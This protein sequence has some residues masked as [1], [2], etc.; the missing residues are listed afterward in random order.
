MANGQTP[1][2]SA[3]IGTLLSN[4]EA[5]SGIMSL[6]KN[7]GISLNKP[8]AADFIPKEDPPKTDTD[9]K[10]VAVRPSHNEKD[11]RF[12]DRDEDRH[13]EKRQKNFGYNRK[14]PGRE[15]RERL[16]IALRPYLSKSRYDTLDEI[17]K[18]ASILELFRKKGG[19]K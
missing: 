1:D 14:K 3:L 13:E 9:V 15:D 18:F 12:E 16:L 5:L 6:L 4:P 19:E 11:D 7:S 2:M 8:E 10:E 17:I